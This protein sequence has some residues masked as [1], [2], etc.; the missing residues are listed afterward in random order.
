MTMLWLC[1]FSLVPPG[2]PEAEASSPLRPSQ[3]EPE[4]IREPP[5]PPVPDAVLPPLP[6]DDASPQSAPDDAKALIAK[7]GEA[8]IK[9]DSQLGLAFADR[10]VEADPTNGW[11][12]FDRGDALSGVRRI[13]DAVAAYR[14]AERRF[15]Q[16]EGWGRSVAVW[17]RAHA[18]AQVGRCDEARGSYHDYVVLVEAH[19]L[20][21]SAMA[22]HYAATCNDRKLEAKPSKPTRLEALLI[23]AP[24]VNDDKDRGVTRR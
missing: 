22:S 9:G 2:G 14:E 18:L 15:G 13:D 19:D 5:T 1:M 6:T 12:H 24:K 11:A 21:A 4:P 8:L 10:A 16:K 17:G 23:E 20:E 7:A 3:I